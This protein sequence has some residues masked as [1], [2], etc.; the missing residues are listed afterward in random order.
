MNKHNVISLQDREPISDPL[1]EL[2]QFGA[3]QLIF[4]AVEAELESFMEIYLVHLSL[5]GYSLWAR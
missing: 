4:S 5:T 2:L 1:T 3:K